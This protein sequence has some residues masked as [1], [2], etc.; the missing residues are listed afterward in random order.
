MKEIK[1]LSLGTIVSQDVGKTID[2]YA[3]IFTQ[4]K[5]ELGKTHYLQGLAGMLQEAETNTL[6]NSVK[7]GALSE[8]AFIQ[9]MLGRFKALF[10]VDLT[11]EEF[12]KGWNAMNPAYEAFA[13]ELK[14]AA[15]Y[16]QKIDAQVI[17]YSFTNPLDMQ[18]L[19]KQLKSHGILY[20]LTE[21]GQLCEIDGIAL[22]TAYVAKQPP[23]DL[24][25]SIVRALPEDAQIEY[26]TS[27]Q[28]EISNSTLREASQNLQQSISGIC[29]E[30]N[31]NMVLW[32]KKAEHSPFVIAQNSPRP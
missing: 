10:N 26:V 31:V 14:Q 21:E 17:F 18:Y 20:Q 22:H 2:A 3:N 32:D 12:K 11:V 27:D 8:E 23:L 7:L 24:I 9:G 13:A 19:A 4:K 28:R 1:I 15:E 30:L 16:N 6:I 5:S 25:R 29:A